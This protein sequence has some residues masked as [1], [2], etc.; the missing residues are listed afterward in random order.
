MPILAEYAKERKNK[1]RFGDFVVR[2]A[3]VKEIKEGKGYQNQ[4]INLSSEL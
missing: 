3:Y 1:E 4:I 2:K